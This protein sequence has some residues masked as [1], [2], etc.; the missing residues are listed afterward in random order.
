MVRREE[1]TSLLGRLET[2]VD[3]AQSAE[4]WETDARDHEEIFLRHPKASSTLPLQ[5]SEKLGGKIPIR[6]TSNPVIRYY[7]KGK[8]IS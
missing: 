2:Y 1:E 6:K 5:D 8:V 3:S 7:Q 4:P